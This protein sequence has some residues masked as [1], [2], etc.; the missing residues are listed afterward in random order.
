[1]KMTIERTLRVIGL[2][3]LLAGW[4][5]LASTAE[6]DEV[7]RE[8]LEAKVDEARA[9]LDEAAQE[10]GELHRQLYAI[11]TVGSHGRKPVL[12]VLIGERGESGGLVLAGV[13]PGS[14]ADEAGLLAGDELT[15]VNN[16]DLTAGEQP[17]HV[18]AEAMQG[19]APG[20]TISVGYQRDGSFGLVEVETASKGMYIMRMGGMP[21]IDISIEDREALKAMG[22]E[23]KRSV[24]RDIGP[25][26]R[27]F[28]TRAFRFGGGL[29][30]EDMDGDLAGYFGVEDGVLVV[31]VPESEEGFPLKGGDVLLSIGGET[32]NHAGAAYQALFSAEAALSVEV[33]R[34][35]SHTNI[36]VDP[37]AL[38]GRRPHSMTIRQIDGDVTSDLD[39]RIVTP[40]QP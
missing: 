13:T 27:R 1:M 23:I 32:T 37:S 31:S 5:G 24:S 15:S 2:L 21:D 17:M 25:H 40:D 7:Q 38:R 28:A 8:E 39:V 4:P 6:L 12:G 33:L 35:G 30:L 20:D 29:R 14:G 18:L 26:A 10:L 22:E 19:V 9:R 11:E 16:V 36:D 34:Q 3:A